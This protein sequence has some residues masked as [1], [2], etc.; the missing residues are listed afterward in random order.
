MSDLREMNEWVHI[1]DT[2]INWVHIQ[3]QLGVEE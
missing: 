2:L 3:F 1:E